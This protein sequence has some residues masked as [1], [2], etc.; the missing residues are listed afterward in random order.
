MGVLLP[1]ELQMDWRKRFGG[2]PDLS[3]KLMKILKIKLLFAVVNG[4]KEAGE[5]KAG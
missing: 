5:K 2:V 3:W 4:A 1:R